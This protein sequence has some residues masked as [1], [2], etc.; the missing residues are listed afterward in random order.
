MMATG[1]LLAT[2]VSLAQQNPPAPP[3]PAE[4][5]PVASFG[6][7]KGAFVPGEILVKFEPG[8]LGR[9]KAETHRRLHGR[10]RETI[11]GLDV[12]V[13]RVPKGQE[14]AKVA[15][16]RSNPNVEYAELNGIATTSDDPNDP[17]DNTIQYTSSKHGD[18]HQWAWRKVQAY[19]TWG[20]M[21]GYAAVKVAIIDTGIDNNHE[22]L[23]AVVAQKDFIN[24]DDN[25]ND[26]SGHGTHVAGTIGALSDNRTG[27]AGAYWNS[28]GDAGDMRSVELIVAKALGASGNGSYSAIASAIDWSV[29]QGADAINLSLGGFLQS[30]TIE[31]AVNRAWNKG[32]VLACS[33]GNTGNSLKSYPAAYDNCIAVAATD[34][35]DRKAPFSTYGSWVDVAAPGVEILSTTPNSKVYLNTRY[36]YKQNYDSLSGT[37]MATPHVAGLAGLV[38]ATDRS[39]SSASCVR[40]K[41]EES[42]DQISGTG[43]YWSK[44]RVN[45]F[46]AVQ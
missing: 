19:E 8:T 27:V 9:A 18:L 36:G 5:T 14:K 37:S 17:Y 22:D 35:A 34:R 16:Y 24:G 31:R 45:F 38:R 28:I 3:S 12:Q 11:P 32:T 1:I 21:K 40:T 33:A 15:A 13:L 30:K 44:G 41:I 4:G 26:D 2:G 29:N 46:K 43:T 25:A 10:V 20:E 6:D 23:P 42:A 7:P 39:C